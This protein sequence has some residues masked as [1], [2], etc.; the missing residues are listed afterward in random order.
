[1]I[2]FP[3][4]R[5]AWYG[6]SVPSISSRSQSAERLGGATPAQ[7]AGHPDR[8]RVVG[9]QHVLAAVGEGDRRLQRLRERGAPRRARS[10]VP[11]PPWIAIFFAFAI[12]AAA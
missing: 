2:V 11:S 4:G 7:Q 5:N 6:K 1:M 3:A 9:L 10:R 8:G 12:I